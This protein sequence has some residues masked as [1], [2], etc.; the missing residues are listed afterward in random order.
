MSTLLY[1]S[2]IFEGWVA[3]ILGLILVAALLSARPRSIGHRLL[4][5]V[6]LCSVYRQFLLV[7]EISGA[8]QVYPILFRTSFPLQLLSI[9]AFYL[10]VNALTT[11]EFKLE[12]RHVVH[13]IPAMGGIVW[14]FV[15]W[16]WGSPEYFQ[17]GPT[18]Y[19]DRYIRVIVKVLVVIPY[20]I[21]ARRHVDA[22]AQR[23]KDHASDVSPL[24]LKWLRILFVIAYVSL[25]VDFLDVL[26]GPRIPVW[27]LIPALALIALITLSYISLRVSPV[28]AR[29]V[30]SYKEAAPDVSEPERNGDTNRSRLSDQELQRQRERLTG[31][32]E[33]KALYLNPELRLSDLATALNIRPYRVSEILSR[34][35]QT[36][37]YDLINSYRVAKAQ[38]LLCSRD[39][40]HL[41]LLGIAMESG[42]KSKS[43]FNDV[44]KKMTGKTPS[45]FR[46]GRNDRIA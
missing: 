41:N 44:F 10:Y 1:R 3:Q 21:G 15:I 2:I 24:R 20:L 40:A 16:V 34:G 4:A 12:G 23:T 9:S 31:V 26:A 29:E 32:L 13:L 5:V 25:A 38:E 46:A 19:R 22:F 35:L 18:Y 36:S 8:V 37:F 28:F 45:Q 27:Y 7:M 14:Y 11:P 42:F 39:S 17:L 30:Q 43:V 6:L 33:S